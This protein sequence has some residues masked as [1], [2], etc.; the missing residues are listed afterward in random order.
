MNI[1]VVNAGSSSLKCKVIELPSQEVLYTKHIEHIGEKDSPLQSY[2]TACRFLDINYDAIDAV[3]HRVV[4][5]GEKFSHA[6]VIDSEVTK[7]IEELT[8]LAPLHNPANLAV[9]KVLQQR[10]QK[11]PHIAVFDTAFHSTLKKEAYLY[12][13][14]YEFYEKEH[15]RRYGFHGTSHAYLLKETAQQLGKNLEE[16]NLIT[17]H[18][19]NGESICAIKNGQ[20]IDISMGFTPLEG[21]IMGSR[22]GDIDAEI[23]L[24]M[25][26]NLGY[27]VDEVDEILNQLSGL[28]GICGENDVRSILNRD[29]EYAKLA[30]DMMVRR[31][32]KYIGSYLVLLEGNVDAL[33]FSGGIG[34][35]S[36]V[37]RDKILDNPMFKNIRTFVIET[38]EELEIAQESLKV[39]ENI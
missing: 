18:L 22:S 14:P 39:L 28:R 25:Q 20:S 34:E 7:T 17:L 5:G 2:A 36:E 27:S 30:I 1:L 3:G 4:H 9:I 31:I 32:Q 29:D 21:L 13:L 26:K 16:T 15:I 35:H 19:G 11:V 6:T 38:D 37:V 10:M 23:V 12:A 8:A 24:Y 33:V